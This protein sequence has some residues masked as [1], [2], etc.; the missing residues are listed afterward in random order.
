MSIAPPETRL[1]ENLVGGR[2]V[3]AG[4]GEPLDDR[5]PATG[6]PLARVPLSTEADVDAAITPFN[7]PAMIPLWFTPFALAT[8]NAI[9]L[10]PSE[11]DPLPAVRIA[12]L[13]ADLPGLPPGTVGL[14]HGDRTAVDALCA[15]P[16]VDAVSF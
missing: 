1:L 5:D 6:E 13:C 9:V 3:P 7:F 4:D 10:K 2:W 15:H 14:V 11:R 8:G 16:R 12:E